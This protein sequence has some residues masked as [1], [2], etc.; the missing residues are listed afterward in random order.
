LGLQRQRFAKRRDIFFG[1]AAEHGV[2]GVDPR[3]FLIGWEAEGA[4]GELLEGG[5]KAA[6]GALGVVADGGI[7]LVVNVV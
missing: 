6:L 2:N 3:L 7:E 5:A 1:Q 4:A